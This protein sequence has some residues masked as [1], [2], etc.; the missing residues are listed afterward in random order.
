MI[1]QTKY[2]CTAPFNYTEVYDDKQFLCCPSWLPVDINN[3]DGISSS[4]NSDKA[5]EIR[6]SILDGSY[7]YCDKIQCPFLSRL[8]NNKI[9]FNFIPKTKESIDYFKEISKPSIINFCFDRSC[10]FQCPSCRNELINYTG[11]DRLSVE[12]KLKEVE[13][14]IS[15]FVK[16]IYLSGSADP[17]FS[18]SFRQFLINLDINKFKNLKFIHLHTNGSLWTPSMWE[19]MKSIHRFVKSCEI[20]ID[21]AKKETYENKVRIG[22][23]WETLH[24]NLRFITLIPNI[25]HY[26]FS[27]VVQ[28]SNYMEMFD[29]YKM[30]ENYMNK[31]VDRVKWEVKTNIITNWATFSDEE[32]L[33]KDVSDINHKDHS[34][35]LD[36]IDRVKHFPNLIHNFHHLYTDNQKLI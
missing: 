35:F 36:E 25:K 33:K 12:K 20:S 6:E 13:N 14:E 2:I 34:K 17:F 4:F 16:K 10:N 9:P 15:P 5:K 3:G 8:K 22:G 28:D 19:K 7:K 21:A 11:N 24:E 23:N 30:I 26:T 1:D 18:K 27:F 29:F 31:R 32:F